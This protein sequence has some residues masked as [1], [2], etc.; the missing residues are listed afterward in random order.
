MGPAWAVLCGAVASGAL[1]LDWH[2]VVT[3]PLAVLLA[4]SLL[5][6]VWS[7]VNSDLRVAEGAPTGNPGR[8]TPVPSLPYTLPGSASARFFEFLSKRMAWWRSTVWPQKGNLVLGLAFN[9]LL[10]LLVSAL[11]GGVPVLLTAIALALAGCRLVLRSSR[12]GVRLALGSCFLAGLPWLLGYTSFGDLGSLGSEPGVTVEAL[13]MAAIYALAYHS[14]Q[15]LSA[16]GLSGGAALL[17]LAHVTAAA[18]LVVVKQPILAGGVA[19]LFLPQLLLQPALL[20]THDGLG[21]LRQVQAPTMAAMMVT[22]LATA[23]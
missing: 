2:T 15:V 9:S 23:V 10:A 7:V 8:K 17:N 3:L 20:T 11:L 5:G 12:E 18:M 16:E 21:Y 13:A 6:S 19:L 4:D 1:E 14:Y 22:A